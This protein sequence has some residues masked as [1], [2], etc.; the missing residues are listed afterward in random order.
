M[1]VE[2]SDMKTLYLILY[3]IAAVLFAVAIFVPSP[4]AGSPLSRFH[5]VA[6]GLFAWVLVDVIRQFDVISD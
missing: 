2:W 4:V 3:I 5:L 6:A 1:T